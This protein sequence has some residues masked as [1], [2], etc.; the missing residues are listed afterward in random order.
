MLA[1]LFRRIY[2]SLR[3][4]GVLIFDILTPGHLART[5]DKVRFQ[6]GPDWATV[7][8]VEKDAKR[9]ELLRRITSFRA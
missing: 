7:V 1:Q 9:R 3:P 4:G 2:A 6:E 5:R 8:Q